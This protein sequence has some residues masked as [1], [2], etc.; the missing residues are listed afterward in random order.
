MQNRIFE[1]NED[2]LEFEFVFPEEKRE[3]KEEK[4]KKS[5]W[6]EWQDKKRCWI[7]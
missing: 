3:K 4:E 2:L 6:K 1:W 7:E 5:D